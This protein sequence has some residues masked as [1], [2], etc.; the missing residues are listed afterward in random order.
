[1]A[2]KRV[3]TETVGT[4]FGIAAAVDDAGAPTPVAVCGGLLEGA[5][6]RVEELFSDVAAGRG[7]D[8]EFWVT[9]PAAARLASG[10][11][12]LDAA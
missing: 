3:K 6:V 9:P 5:V 1:M 2:R 4:G 8:E 11:W 10:C 12:L 7:V